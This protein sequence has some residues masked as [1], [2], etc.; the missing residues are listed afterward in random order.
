MYEDLN[1]IC[2][3]V[4]S[5]LG[6]ESGIYFNNFHSLFKAIFRLTSFGSEYIINLIWFKLRRRL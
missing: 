4:K 5:T 1:S 2:A 3:L 6:K